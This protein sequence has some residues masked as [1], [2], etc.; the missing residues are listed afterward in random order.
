MSL[1]SASIS[2]VI[3]YINSGKYGYPAEISLA[4]PQARANYYSLEILVQNCNSGC[5]GD[6]LNGN[7]NELLVEDIKVNTSGNTD[8]ELLGGA[9]LI[10]GLKFIYFS[11]QNFNG[12]SLTLKFIIVPTLIDLNKDQN[13]KFVL[14]SITP[15]YYQYLRT[16]DFQQELEKEGSPSE[17]VQ[18]AT[19]IENG[20]GTFAGYSYSI[21]TIKP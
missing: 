9:Q 8:I 3:Q 1:S 15:E 4:D 14:K 19:N 13:I 10:D 17:P 20:L 5:T 16:S 21:Y 18:I 6:D 2:S 12:E 7:L 11:D